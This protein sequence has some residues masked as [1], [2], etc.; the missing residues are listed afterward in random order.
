MNDLS[1][2]WCTRGQ[3]QNS[4]CPQERATNS[5]VDSL[6][7]F[8]DRRFSR[9]INLNWAYHNKATDI[10]L[11]LLLLFFFYCWLL[12]IHKYCCYTASHAIALIART[13]TMCVRPFNPFGFSACLFLLCTLVPRCTLVKLLFMFPH[14]VTKWHYRNLVTLPSQNVCVLNTFILHCTWLYIS[15]LTWVAISYQQQTVCRYLK[16][17]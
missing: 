12:Y 8:W 13:H 2:L 9:K 4:I 6:S 3:M 15:C 5:T 16:V 11:L 14:I 1:E 10:F 7:C 17:A